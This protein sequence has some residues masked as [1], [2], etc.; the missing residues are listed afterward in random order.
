MSRGKKI[1]EYFQFSKQDRVAILAILFLVGLVFLL[2]GVTGK[3]KANQEK[4]DT[5]WITAMKR[6]EKG[7][8]L[9][10]WP[11]ESY[12]DDNTQQYQYDRPTGHYTKT[13]GEVFYFDPNTLTAEGWQRLGLREKTIHTIQNYLSKGGKFRKPEDVQ[14]IYGLFP[15]EYE[16]IAPYIRIESA[17]GAENV[18]EP[19]QAPPPVPKANNPRYAVTDVNS[20]DTSALIVLPGIGSKLASR[21]IGFRDKLGG[22]YSINQVAETYGLPD[23]TFQRIKQYLRAD[24]PVKKININTA[25]ADELKAHPYIKWALANPITAYRKEHGLFAK[26]EDLKKVMAV[27]EEAYQKIAPYV[28]VN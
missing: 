5:S 6:L 12:R 4:L 28:T 25:T 10:E 17:G 16:R 19:K 3:Q 11:N 9:T 8:P 23:S 24:S 7:S 27:T 18:Y 2:P 26:P 14:R 1:V 21:I 13:K 22:F 15:D 20:A